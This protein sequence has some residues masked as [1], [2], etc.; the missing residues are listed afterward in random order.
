[1]DGALLWNE[2]LKKSH[3]FLCNG[4]RNVERDALCV[5]V[6]GTLV[7]ITEFL[8]DFPGNHCWNFTFIHVLFF[9]CE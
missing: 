3:S 7:N 5:S 2:P 8:I 9:V 1:M 6:A 4:Y